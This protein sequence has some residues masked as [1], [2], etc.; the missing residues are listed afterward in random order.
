[1]PDARARARVCVCV[2]EGVLFFQILSHSSGIHEIGYAMRSST[3]NTR[4]LQLK[5]MWRIYEI[6][7]CKWRYRYVI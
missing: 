2:C 6:L 5:V 3:P 1:M 7:S 4:F